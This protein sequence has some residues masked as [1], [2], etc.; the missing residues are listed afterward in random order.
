MVMSKSEKFHWKVQ[1]AAYE[2]WEEVAALGPCSRVRMVVASCT[3]GALVCAGCPVPSIPV[4]WPT[5][6]G[7]PARLPAP[8]DLDLLPSPLATPA[9]ACFE[10]VRIGW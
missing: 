2:R 4:A 3:V 5:P 8:G 9:L 6:L 10:G 1:I 7:Y